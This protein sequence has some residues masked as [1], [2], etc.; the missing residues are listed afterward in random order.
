LGSIFGQQGA[1]QLAAQQGFGGFLTGLGAQA[2]QAGMQ[3]I[4]SLQGIGGQQQ[5]LQQQ[6][7]D[8]QR[9]ALL[10]AQQAP[11]AQYQALMP[12][13]NQAVGISGSGGSSTVQYTPPPNPLSAAMQTGLGAFGMFGQVGQPTMYGQPMTMTGQPASS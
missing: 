13:V 9:A 2:Q 10:Q 12:F 8:A 5:Q 4:A 11:L 7:Y 6:R 3:D 1:Q